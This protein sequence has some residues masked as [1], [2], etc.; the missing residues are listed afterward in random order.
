MAITTGIVEDNKNLAR[1]I[2]ESLA[3]F[4]EINVLFTAANGQEALQKI[5]QSVPDV[6]LMDI[7]M[8]VM[9]GIEATR[10]VHHLF[11][12]VRIV[13]LTVFD[14]SEK[15]FD[16][17][18][19]GA[20]GYLLKDEKAIKIVEALQEAMDGGAPMSASIAFKSLQLIRGRAAG[21]K[22]DD[23]FNLTEREIEILEMIARGDNYL[24]IA[25]KIFVAPKTVRKHIENIYR[26]MQVHNKAEAVRVAMEK[27][28]V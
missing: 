3:P 22:A 12:S 25:E 17:I 15:I 10:R 16:A 9:D 28:I 8:P 13:M 5:A 24:Q 7:H 19:A 2:R 14:E 6:L 11:P 20:T 4:S 21:Q 1:S 26:K 27:K 18:L 23:T